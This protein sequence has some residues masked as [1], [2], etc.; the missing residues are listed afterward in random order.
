MSFTKKR[1]VVMTSLFDILIYKV[2]PHEFEF[3]K[4]H[5]Q[6]FNFCNF[7]LG[8]FINIFELSK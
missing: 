7:I 3:R 4:D 6:V 2:L 5:H 1:L 8:K